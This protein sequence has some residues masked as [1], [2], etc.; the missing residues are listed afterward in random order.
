MGRDRLLIETVLHVATDLSG[1]P[2]MPEMHDPDSCLPGPFLRVWF[3]V[4]TLR[5]EEI[6][7]KSTCVY[8]L[9]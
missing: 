2:D 5:D 3:A 1:V 4:S 7:P 8:C 6:A 9:L